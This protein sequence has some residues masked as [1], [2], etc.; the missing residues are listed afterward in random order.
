MIKASDGVCQEKSA[1]RS[2]DDLIGFTKAKIKEMQEALR[3]F[4]AAK[5]R[6]DK[7]HSTQA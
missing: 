5:K 7:W 6:G 3:T 2:W 4:Q 1:A